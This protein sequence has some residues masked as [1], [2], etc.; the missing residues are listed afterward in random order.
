[1]AR[2]TSYP[3]KS[4]LSVFD[5]TA[6]ELTPY[7]L[8]PNFWT[9]AIPTVQRMFEK[10]PG[11]MFWCAKQA[12]LNTLWGETPVI[13][14]GRPDVYWVSENEM[15][16]EV[17]TLQAMANDACLNEPGSVVPYKLGLYREMLQKSYPEANIECF[18]FSWLTGAT[19]I[20][21]FGT[22]TKRRK[23]LI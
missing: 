19:Y 13:I 23:K 20:V 7:P 10:K 9:M 1:V 17:W 2:I 6:T 16:L 5:F 15:K 12:V 22:A 21:P 18:V 14:A 8:Q 3:D 11:K 4:L